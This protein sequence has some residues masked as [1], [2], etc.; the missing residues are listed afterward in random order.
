MLN[1]YSRKSKCTKCRHHCNRQKRS[2]WKE[3][4]SRDAKTLN[5]RLSTKPSTLCIFG[6]K[7][8]NEQ[9]LKRRPRHDKSMCE[10]SNRQN[11][12]IITTRFWS[13]NVVLFLV[14]QT[15]AQNLPHI[16]RYIGCGK[17]SDLRFLCIFSQ[18]L[19]AIS[20]RNV[21]QLSIL[22]SYAHITEFPGF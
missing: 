1:I 11:T 9:I 8:C 2:F 14:V 10:P 3:S 22:T 18:K 16:H 5:F 21:T 4:K 17:S 7:P 6:Q 15:H 20:K 12:K 13:T 19:H